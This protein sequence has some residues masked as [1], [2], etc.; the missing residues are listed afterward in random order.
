LDLTATVYALGKWTDWSPV[1]PFVLLNPRVDSQ[2]AWIFRAPL[3]N[4]VVTAATFSMGVPRCDNRMAYILSSCG[5]SVLNTPFN[6]H[7]IEVMSS[8]R[9]DTLYSM[10]GAAVGEGKHIYLSTLLK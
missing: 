10:D 5:Y 1:Q 2:D 4:C 6:I 7:A 3:N 9:A 8:G